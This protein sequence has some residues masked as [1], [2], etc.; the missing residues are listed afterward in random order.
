MKESD[1]GGKEMANQDAIRIIKTAIA[2]IEWEYPMEYAAAFDR[3]IEVLEQE[4]CEDAISR[5]SVLRLF[6][7]HDGKYLYEAIQELPSVLPEQKTGHWI[8]GRYKDTCSHCRCTYPKDIG[9]KNYCPNCGEKM[10][11]SE[12]EE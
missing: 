4:P 3:A 7:T 6:A 2:E 12:G 1:N 5:E 9:F 10:E 8:L 11:E